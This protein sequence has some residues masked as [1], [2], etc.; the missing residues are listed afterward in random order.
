MI[1]LRFAQQQ[2]YYKFKFNRIKTG[3]TYAK[4]Q[5]MFFQ[6]S[7]IINRRSIANTP[8]QY[9]FSKVSRI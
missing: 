7:L 3:F 1:T 6:I 4:I 8:Y 5:L 2:L 9:F